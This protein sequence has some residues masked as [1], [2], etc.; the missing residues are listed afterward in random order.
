MSKSDGN[1]A[2]P[3]FGLPKFAENVMRFY[4]LHEAGITDDGNNDE[5]TVIT[6]LKKGYTDGLGKLAHRICGWKFDLEGAVK[7]SVEFNLSDIRSNHLSAKHTSIS[8]NRSSQ[9]ECRSQSRT[10][11]LARKEST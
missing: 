10:T 7:R 8:L 9:T 5:L 6:G 11:G 3:F 1:A 2:N 4:L